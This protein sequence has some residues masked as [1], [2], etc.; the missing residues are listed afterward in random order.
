MRKA[1]VVEFAVDGAD[2]SKAAATELVNR[3]FE[4]MK[5]S[6]RKEEKFSYPGFG[7]LVMRKRKARTGRD[8]RTGKKIQIKAS[9][10][11]AF[12]PASSFKEIL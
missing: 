1:E 8:P 7:T 4:A 10:T 12:R 11:V 6:V 3:V 9:R 5:Q 2:I